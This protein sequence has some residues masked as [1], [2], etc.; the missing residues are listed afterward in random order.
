MAENER[1]MVV[2]DLHLSVYLRPLH[3]EFFTIRARRAFKQAT[4][5]A[6]VWLLDT[7][8]VI[9]FIDG[10]QVVTEVVAPRDLRLPRRGLIREANVAGER[11]QRV[12]ARGPIVYRTVYHVDA[13]DPA[14]YR[15]EVEELLAGAQQGHLFVEGP[16]DL[17][18]R[19]F[20]YALPELRVRSLLVH[21][22]HG[23][24]AESTI[25]KTQTLIEEAR[26]G[27]A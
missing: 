15:R 14:T 17:G 2:G 13:Q 5:E 27:E 11:E 16:R 8:H 18:R 25:L 22:W 21:T 20:S 23:F 7:G 12:E 9:S 24:P 1:Q 19:V 3:P 10:E 6:E 4:F 26:R